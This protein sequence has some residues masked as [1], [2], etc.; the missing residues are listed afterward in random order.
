[1]IHVVT[2]GLSENQEQTAQAAARV[3]TPPAH[4]ESSATPDALLSEPR[5]G[6]RGVVLAKGISMAEAS[7][8]ASQIDERGSRRWSL[9]ILD[10]GFGSGAHTTLPEACFTPASGPAIVK[11]ALGSLAIETENDRM[12]GD[13]VVMSRRISHDLK[14]PLSAIVSATEVIKD[15]LAP[16]D[17]LVQFANSITDSVAEQERTL[18]RASFVLKATAIRE[19]L[20]SVAM[21]E[22]VLAMLQRTEHRAMNKNVRIKTPTQWPQVDGISSWLETIWSDLVTNAIDHGSK[23]GGEVVIGWERAEG[24][25]RFWVRDAGPGVPQ[26]RIKMLF[27]PFDLLH[28]LDAPRGLGL[29]I[30]QRL[31]ELQGGRCEY[32]AAPEGGAEFSF[33]LPRD[34][35]KVGV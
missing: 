17:S 29:P 27:Y 18:R 23:P 15:G 24:V 22:P 1:M 5:I 8:L 4:W 35:A 31:V 3:M 9:V 20:K 2:I 25:Y 32:R 10:G 26:E 7:A 28:R 16:G 11:L 30:V 21:E 14:A 12:R 34:E 19:T 13:M 6:K 33:L